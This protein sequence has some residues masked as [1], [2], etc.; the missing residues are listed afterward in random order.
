MNSKMKNKLKFK[1]LK[2]KWK[3]RV[4]EIELNGV[5]LTTPVFMPV[6]TKA[7]VKAILPEFLLNSKFWLGVE[8]S[9][10]IILNN[11]FH[12]YLR[13]GDKYIKKVWWLHKFQ[14]WPN[15]ILTDSWGFQVFSLGL[16]NHRQSSNK[17]QLPSLVKLKEDGVEFRSPLDG[18][19]HFFTPERVVDI[20][21]N[22]WSDIMM[23]LDVCSP[24]HNI[25]KE[26]VEY[27]MNL[28]HRW[29][30]RAFE[31]FLPKYNQ[32]RGVLFPIVQWWIYKDLREESAKFLSQFAIDGIAIGGLSV[33]ETKDQ[34]YEVL[35]FLSD[36]LP[37]DK[38]RYLMGVWT[39]EDIRQAIYEWVD[40]FD[41]VLPT[42][43]GRHG[44]VF[45]S[46]WLLKLRNAKYREDFRPIDESC[47]CY[48]CRTFTRAYLHHLIRENEI[49]ASILLSLHNIAYLHRLVEDIKKEILE[50]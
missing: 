41:C 22:L 38:P 19:K 31:Y 18:S 44:T 27:Q 9:V 4:G 8:S 33:W 25:S 23:V 21:M 1:V 13:P 35:N 30:K 43:L 2:T 37:K 20:Q 36:L 26:E 28:T 47:G 48:T 16:A 42:R 12:L 40:M 7:A 50:E 14:S 46:E 39:P 45:S 11:T 17:S 5:K 34:M 3:A 10:K 6:G 24:V 29:A 15:L 32:A 49:N